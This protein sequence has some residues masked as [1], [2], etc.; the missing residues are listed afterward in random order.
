MRVKALQKQVESGKDNSAERE[1]SNT[2][3]PSPTRINVVR[4]SI[5]LDQ[6]T[7][8]PVDAR[9]RDFATDITFEDRKPVSRRLVQV[10]ILKWP[11]G[12]MGYKL[13]DAL[14]KGLGVERNEMNMVQFSPERIFEAWTAVSEEE[15]RKTVEALYDSKIDFQFLEME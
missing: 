6:P 8:A 5:A 2:G 11:D 14:Q 4:Q 15:F 3:E 13:G 7:Q 10:V 9:K 12:T 1:Q